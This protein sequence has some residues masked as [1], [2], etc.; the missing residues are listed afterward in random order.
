MELFRSSVAA[1]A[2]ITALMGSPGLGA[3]EK[4]EPLVIAGQGSFAAGG[5]VQKTP[6][7]YINNAPTARG[8]SFHGDHLYAFYQIPE[9]P[10]GLPIVMLHGAYQ[11]GRSWETTPD[12]REG[13][14][15][16]FL[17]R[18]FTTYVVD[19]PRRGRAGNSTIP[20]LTK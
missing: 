8:Q 6:G 18:H 13:F 10:R 3:E 2:V 7:I 9:K 12:G 20:V 5:T 15:T 14:Q 16:L 19:Q 4:P 17:R 11:S 1:F